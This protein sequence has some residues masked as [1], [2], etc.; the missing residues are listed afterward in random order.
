M[1][2]PESEKTDIF[3]SPLSQP[4]L[5]PLPSIPPTRPAGQPC[6]Y[7][8]G[9]KKGCRELERQEEGRKND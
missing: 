2:K 6:T 3:G 1:M 8:K 5:Q 9:K 4:G 7:V